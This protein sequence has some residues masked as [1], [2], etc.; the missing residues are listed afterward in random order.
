MNKNFCLLPTRLKEIRTRRKRAQSEI[1]RELGIPQQTYAHWENGLRQPKL[2]MLM[3]LC[4]H[5]GVSAD[6]L[7]GLDSA[8]NTAQ[9]QSANISHRI[10]DLKRNVTEANE[11]CAKLLATID[12]LGSSI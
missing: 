1:A 12:N 7:L 6:W 4:L 9:Q 11:S 8:M 2:D 10:A 5:F 3:R